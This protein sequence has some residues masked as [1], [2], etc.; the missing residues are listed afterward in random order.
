MFHRLMDAK[1]LRM[2]VMTEG[3]MKVMNGPYWLL[4]PPQ[5]NESL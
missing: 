4:Q 3:M 1:Y 2:T 5:T